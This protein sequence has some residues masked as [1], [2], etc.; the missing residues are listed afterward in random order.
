MFCAVISP[1]QVATCPVVPEL[2][3]A[4][5]HL[6]QWRRRSIVFSSFGTMVLFTT[7][8]AAELSIWRG[9]FGCGHFI[10][11]NV[12]RIATISCAMMNIAPSSDSEAEDMTNLINFAN[13]S[14]GP[15][16]RGIASFPERKICAPAL[17][18]PLL[19][20]WNPTF[21][22]AQRTILLER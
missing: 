22:C 21:E 7:P 4:Y 5:L 1:V 10:S 13:V 14:T 19:S 12:C 6:I 18:R 16:H 17:L 2:T 3:C 20:L 11:C 15:F 8:A 9:D